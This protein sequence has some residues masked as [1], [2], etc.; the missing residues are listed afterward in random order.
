MFLKKRKASTWPLGDGPMTAN[1][2]RANSNMKTRHL[3]CNF[4]QW[5]ISSNNSK[6]KQKNKK[7]AITVE[8][9]DCCGPIIPEKC[10][11]SGSDQD[12]I[13]ILPWAVK[14]EC[15]FQVWNEL[16]RVPAQKD[17]WGQTIHSKWNLFCI[18]W[19]SLY[20]EG[21]YIRRRSRVWIN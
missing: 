14:I 20:I 16:S 19:A 6:Y 3:T 2:W 12:R 4:H 7:Y 21:L 18:I 9:D 10:T 15:S 11:E 8:I 17:C 1:A 13:Q 5:E